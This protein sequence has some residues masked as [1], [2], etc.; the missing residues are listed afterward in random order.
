MPTAHVRIHARRGKCRVNTDFVLDDGNGIPWRHA[1]EA[2]IIARSGPVPSLSTD[3]APSPSA[4]RALARGCR[5]SW[6]S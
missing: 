2:S 6:E 5:W 3:L 4:G 1:K